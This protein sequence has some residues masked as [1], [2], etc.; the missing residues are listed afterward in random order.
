MGGETVEAR[1]LGV[2]SKSGEGEAGTGATTHKFT[3]KTYWFAR[4]LDDDVYEIQPLNGNHVPSGLTSKISKGDF[5]R[6]YS[7]ELD[8][9]Q[10]KTLPCL[11]SLQKKIEKGEEYLGKDQLDLAEKEFCKAVLIDDKNVKA[12]IGL[13]EVYCRKQDLT[14]LKKTLDVL[15][16][17]DLVFLEEQRRQFNAFGIDLRKNQFFDEAKQYYEK[18]LSLQPDDDH[19]H[20]NL[21]RVHYDLVDVGAAIEHLEQALSLN[22]QFKVARQF[23][24]HCLKLSGGARAPS[25]LDE[26][27]F[28]EDV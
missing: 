16:N 22:P 7:P 17:N 2:Y 21:A 12:T 6:S 25:P 11:Q 5:I 14:K 3:Q 9:F 18:A 8:Y 10:K 23:L 20:F 1:V 19:L 28:P 4:R 15:L 26:I 24:D 13:G 27:I